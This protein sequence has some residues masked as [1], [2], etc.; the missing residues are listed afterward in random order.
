MRRQQFHSELLL[1]DMVSE[2][3]PKISLFCCNSCKILLLFSATYCPT[4]ILC[5]KFSLHYSYSLQILERPI[6]LNAALN[7]LEVETLPWWTLPALHWGMLINT[8]QFHYVIVRWW[9]KAMN[10][11]LENNKAVVSIL[12]WRKDC[13]LWNLLLRW[14]MLLLSVIWAD[15]CCMDDFLCWICVGMWWYVVQKMHWPIKMSSV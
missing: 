7:F 2:P 13:C 9:V 8:M 14:K 5:V 12:C 1:P 4:A 10:A 15:K 11:A 3:A 6:W